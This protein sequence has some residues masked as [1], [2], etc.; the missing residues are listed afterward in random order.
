MQSGLKWAI[1]ISTNF[2]LCTV[3]KYL[4]RHVSKDVVY[5]QTSIIIKSKI[6]D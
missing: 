5:I 2:Y 1:T 3:N 4:L 6:Y